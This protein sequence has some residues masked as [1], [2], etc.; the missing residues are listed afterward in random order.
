MSSGSGET[1]NYLL[2]DNGKEFDNGDIRGLCDKYGIK[3]VTT[4]PYHPQ[5]NPTE[6][7]NRTIKGMIRIFVGI[8]HRD[9][10][11]HLPAFRSAMNTATQSTTKVS[12]AFLNFGRH[13]QPVKS[14]RRAVEMTDKPSV[15]SSDP[16]DWSDRIKLLDNLRELVIKHI[17]N[18]REKQKESYDVGRKDV[19]FEVGDP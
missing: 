18:A 15:V 13:P 14:L 16:K 1:T 12:P 17:D 6:R 10:D 3:F 7:S 8:H 2:T 5:S 9:W 11:K 4:R 19:R